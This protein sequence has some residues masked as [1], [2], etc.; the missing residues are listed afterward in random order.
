M[1]VARQC[2]MN[3]V[4]FCLGDETRENVEDFFGLRKGMG[5]RSKSQL[6]FSAN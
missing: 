4:L 1:G 5:S 6:F 2:G 3:A